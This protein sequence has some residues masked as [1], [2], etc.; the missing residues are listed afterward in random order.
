M[1]SGSQEAIP[2]Q[3]IRT[4]AIAALIGFAAA[5]A[6][7]Q[8]FEVTARL[9]ED[10]KAVYATVESVDVAVA[11]SR[12]AGTINRLTVDEGSVVKAG[13]KIAEVSDPKLGLQR[14]ALDASGDGA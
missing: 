1:G 9:I 8:E 14:V 13:E 2:M 10:R 3:T 12:I 11:R 5:G 6:A 7:A 4:C